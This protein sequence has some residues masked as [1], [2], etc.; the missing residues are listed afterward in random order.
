MPT[1]KDYGFFDDENREYVIT[2]RNTPRNFYNYYFNDCFISFASQVGCGEGL[3]QDEPSNR[4]EMIADRAVYVADKTNKKWFNAL[5]LPMYETFDSFECRHGIGYST[6]ITE[7]E[8]IRTETTFFVPLYEGAEYWIVNVKNLADEKRELGVITYNDHRLDGPYQPQGYNT[9]QSF[10]SDECNAVHTRIL[11]TVGHNPAKFAYGYMMSNQKVHSYDAR[12]TAFIGTYGNKYNPLALMENCGCTKSECI[13]E[14]SV[15]VLEHYA[16]LGKGES[17]SFVVKIGLADSLDELKKLSNSLTLEGAKQLLE[18]IKKV[19]WEQESGVMIKTPDER[20]NSAFNGFY[21]YSTNMGSRW[22]RMRS[23]GYRDIC[24]DTECLGTYSPELAWER[25]TRILKY[26]YSS[27]CCPRNFKNGTINLNKFSDNAVWIAFTAYSLIMELGN[28]ELLDEIVPFNDGSE[29]SVFE[30]IKRAIDYL[31]NF[32]GM[33]GLIKIWGGDW[34]DGMDTAG[35]EEKGVSIW[36]SIAWYGAAKKFMELCR[37]S[38]KENIIPLYEDMAEDMRY[39]IEKYGFEGEYYSIA[40]NDKGDKIG[41]PEC[42]GAKIYLIPQ[43]WAVISDIA[44]KEKL[45]KIMDK[46]EELLGRCYGMLCSYPE[47]PDYN[48]NIGRLTAHPKGTL[49]NA[50]VYLHPMGWKLIVDCMMKRSDR[51]EKTLAQILPWNN[52][53]A[54]TVG[55]PYVLYNYY[56]GSDAGYRYG[57]PGQSW[58]T[59]TTQQVVKATINY[60]FGIKPSLDGIK[61]DCCIPDGWDGCSI[62]KVFRGATYVINYKRGENKGVFV[63]GKNYTNKI[64]PYEQGKTIHV[65]VVYN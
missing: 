12:K 25:F 57:V 44:P 19:R 18:E 42:E 26:Q 45:E 54:P 62:T 34:N 64:L 41:A 16:S 48:P 56:A 40:I 47:Y 17:M 28:I 11:S 46:T 6:I 10:F 52:K 21:K 4:A 39:K 5:G 24:Q 37:L 8:N 58:R 53:Y 23:N 38:G 35:L 33:H 15:H 59:A 60:I 20:F 31:Y 43:L 29:A 14:K 2:E 36:L 7:R 63:M 3:I 27:G 13:V 22:A 30:H 1:Y 65:D 32:Q 9:Y 61:I 51:V 49:T 55:E 50:G